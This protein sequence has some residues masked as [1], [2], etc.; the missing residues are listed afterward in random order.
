MLCIY[1]LIIIIYLFL[2]LLDISCI[3]TFKGS[4]SLEGTSCYHI[5]AANKRNQNNVDTGSHENFQFVI[6]KNVLDGSKRRKHKRNKSENVDAG[7]EPDWLDKFELRLEATNAEERDAWIE[8]LRSCIP[9]I[10]AA[11][12]VRISERGN[13]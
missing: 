1:L 6:R 10:R 13:F 9:D 12:A 11:E 4:I 5:D 8:T 2:L 3:S 7:L